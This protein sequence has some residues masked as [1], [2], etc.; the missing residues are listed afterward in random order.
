MQHALQDLGSPTCTS[1]LV[2]RIRKKGPGQGT[3]GQWLRFVLAGSEQGISLDEI[4][5]SRIDLMLAGGLPAGGR[6]GVTTRESF[7]GADVRGPEP[8]GGRPPRGPLGSL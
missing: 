8:R 2:D 6:R 4:K 7:A 1:S 5:F 3:A